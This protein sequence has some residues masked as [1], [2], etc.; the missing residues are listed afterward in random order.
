MVFLLPRWPRALLHLGVGSTYIL[1]L[2]IGLNFVPA[3]NGNPP[4][5]ADG[6]FC[7]HEIEFFCGSNVRERL[8][9]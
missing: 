3:R 1:G 9:L 7:R 4:R 8:V 2:Q 5:R 6:N